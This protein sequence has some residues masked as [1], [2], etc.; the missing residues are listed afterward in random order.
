VLYLVV[1]VLLEQFKVEELHNFI[2]TVLLLNKLDNLFLYALYRR[3]LEDRGSSF[4][5]FIEQSLH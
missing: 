3:Y 5:I 1:I 2:F 4:L